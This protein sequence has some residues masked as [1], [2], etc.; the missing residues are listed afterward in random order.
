MSSDRICGQNLL[1]NVPKPIIVSDITV[2]SFLKVSHF[3]SNFAPTYKYDVISIG[4]EYSEPNSD[5]LFLKIHSLYR[6]QWG[7]I[8]RTREGKLERVVSS[9]KALKRVTKRGWNEL[10]QKRL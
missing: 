6:E 5:K 7:G 4:M 10:E 2:S 3:F 1:S 8:R 9:R